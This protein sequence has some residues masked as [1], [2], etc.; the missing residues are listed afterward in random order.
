LFTCVFVLFKVVVVFVS[1]I[2]EHIFFTFVRTKIKII[3]WENK[4]TNYE[5][6]KE[7]IKT[8]IIK[9]T[10]MQIW[11]VLLVLLAIRLDANSVASFF[12]CIMNKF[13]SN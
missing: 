10:W 9:L 4:I 6:K 5:E 7:A 11:F 1:Y 3:F 12:E 2:L 8:P 13:L